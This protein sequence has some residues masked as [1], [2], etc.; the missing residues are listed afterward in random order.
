[1]T[2]STN[3]QRQQTNS[4]L[5]VGIQITSS[6]NIRF[7]A[8]S[9][10]PLVGVSR[11]CL[12]DSDRESSE[13]YKPADRNGSTSRIC[14]CRYMEKSSL[15]SLHS[16]NMMLNKGS[17]DKY[18]CQKQSLIFL[19]NVRSKKCLSDNLALSWTPNYHLYIAYTAYTA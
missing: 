16:L 10:R 9:F 15:Y 6:A 11:G 14:I 18:H 2:V 8:F 19:D 17:Q 4:A 5:E 3:E 12:Q 13:L 7:W 1:M